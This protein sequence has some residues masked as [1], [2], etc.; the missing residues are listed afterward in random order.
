MNTTNSNK[1]MFTPEE[2]TQIEAL[3]IYG[4]RG[5]ASDDTY[6]QCVNTNCKCPQ[7]NCPAY[8]T[9]ELKPS[10]SSSCTIITNNNNCPIINQGNGKCD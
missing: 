8:G 10:N 6:N 5:S 9:C 2:L 4:G 7:D 1:M 3:E